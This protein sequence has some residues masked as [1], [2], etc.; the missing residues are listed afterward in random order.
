MRASLVALETILDALVDSLLILAALHVDEVG[1]DDA[2]NVAQAHLTANFIR[3]LEVG[4]QDGLL[5]VFRPLVPAG[6]DVDR[7][8]SLRLV[9]N[10]IS[11]ALQPDLAVEG[12]VDLS[13]NTKAIEDR[14]RTRVV[15]DALLRPR[16][17][18]TDELLN[19]LP[20]PDVID[21]HGV[22][23][24]GKEITH[25][26]LD[27]VRLLE[28]A[29]RRLQFFN[30]AL[31]VLPLLHK[32]A[33]V[34]DEVSCAL[35][36]ADGSHDDAHSLGNVE[37]AQNLA[38]PV[39]FLGIVNL[40]RY[41]ALVVERH[42]HQ[43]AAREADVGG[44]ARPLVADRTLFYLDQDVGTHRVD[45]RNILMGDLLPLLFPDLPGNSFDAAV[46]RRGNGIPEL[47]EGI[48]LKPDVHEHRLDALLDISNL[49]FVDGSDNIAVGVAFCGVLL[50]TIILEQRN[51]LFEALAA[52]N[53]LDPRVLLSEA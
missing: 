13:L 25:R 1:D 6:I 35:A 12:R 27:E 22:D 20:R 34:T 2:A 49:S 3:R 45:P 28:K 14:L 7:D 40:P 11:A 18:L 29:D 10:N 39:S 32:D 38:K 41:A 48:L 43:I 21:D 36:L 9:D 52:D 23:L 31:D 16:R 30:A 17:N 44:N 5:D 8:Q 47:Q 51:A 46:E 19:P 24:I 42:K 50:E 37:F 33:Q 15:L 53:E 26:P 4:L